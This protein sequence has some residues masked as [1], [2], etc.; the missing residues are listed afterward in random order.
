M[1]SKGDS[2]NSSTDG[3]RITPL[4]GKNDGMIGAQRQSEGEGSHGCS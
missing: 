3:G 1:V 4:K 2:S